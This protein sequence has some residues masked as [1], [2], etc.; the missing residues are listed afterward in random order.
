MNFMKKSIS[1]FLII[2]LTLS[3]PLSVQ[4]SA[5]SSVP[6]QYVLISNESAVGDQSENSGSFQI[7][8]DQYASTPDKAAYR[9]DYEK[10]FNPSEYKNK[11]IQR[12]TRTVQAS[13]KVGDSKQFWVSN[14]ASQT[15]D[16]YQISATLKYSGSKT[17]VWVYNKQIT[18]AE[19]VKLGKEFDNKIH[20]LDVNNFGTESD[21]DGNGKVNILCYDIQDGFNGN[22]GY[23]A[24]YFYPGD[25]YNIT[26]SNDSEIFYIDTYPTMG[27]NGSAKDVTKAYSTLAHEFQHMINYNQRVLVHGYSEMDTWMNEGLSM[28]AEQIYSGKTLQD[29]IDY[30]NKDSDIANGHSLLYWDYDKDTLVNYSL[31]Y[32][33]FQYLRIQCGQG[34]GIFKKLIDDRN[35]DYHAVE[36]VIHKYISSKLSFGKFMTDF[37]E[38]LFLRQLWGLYGFHGESGFSSLKSLTYSGASLDLRGGGS[39]V[40]PINSSSSITVPADKGSDITYTTLTLDST[41]PAK[42]KVSGGVSNASASVSG[43]SEPGS[44]V[45]VKNGSKVLGTAKADSKGNYKVTI[46][47]QKAGSKLVVYAIDVSGNK[48]AEVSVTVSDKTPPA[49][50]TINTFGD[51][52]TTI[53]GKAEAYSKVVIKSG[54]T[55][56]GQAIAGSKGTFSVKIKSKQKAGATLTAYAIDKAN[57]QSAGTSFKVADKTAPGIPSVNKVTHKSTHVTGKA[58]KGATVYVYH[59]SK[60][61]GKAAVNSKRCYSVKI[62]QQKK[63]AKLKI[64]AK[65]KAGNKSR[66]KEVKV[67]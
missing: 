55:T 39:V 41:P 53:T 49:K 27:E 4:A 66:S 43:T 60:Y 7:S 63:G 45:T 2:L 8:N 58:E 18:D 37:R 22:G 51:N 15:E 57:N 20:P 33:F 54:K 40:K 56:L 9:L 34:N 23:V 12:S 52:Q 1:A 24:G 11:F 13:Y 59:S 21:V 42:P 61:L 19:A 31:S 46:A 6:K 16:N 17:N 28:A 65:D 32:L 3:V 35:G 38:A 5:S 50:P 10:P 26:D 14:L 64:Y 67:Q 47:K 30:Y 62:H 36:D 29:R 48:S 44:E 25:L